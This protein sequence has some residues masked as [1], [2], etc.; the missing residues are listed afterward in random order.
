MPVHLFGRPAPV[1]ESRSSG[2]RSSRT[3]PRRGA[4]PVPRRARVDL[5]LLPDEEPVLLGDGGLVAFNDEELAER[6]GCSPSTARGTRPIS[7]TSA[8]T[9]ASTRSRPRSCACSCRTRTSGTAS[10]ARRRRATSSSG[11]ARLRSGAR[12]ARARLPHVRRPLAGAGP[13]PRRVDLG[14]DRPAVYYTTPLHL[15]PALR[16]LGYAEGTLPETESA[17]RENFWLPLW[18]ASPPKCR[19]RSCETV[20]S[21]VGARVPS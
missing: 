4:R 7:S 15:Q 14:R 16:Y 11:S 20:R 18:P 1:A 13:A 9:R 8:T 5:Q 6:F 3:P 17:A 12:R 21:A 10:A 19:R 2:C